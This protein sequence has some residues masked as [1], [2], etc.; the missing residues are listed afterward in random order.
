[1]RYESLYSEINLSSR[2]ALLYNVFYLGRRLVFAILAN[3]TG[4]HPGAQV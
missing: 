2:Y 4:H 1:V 3:Q